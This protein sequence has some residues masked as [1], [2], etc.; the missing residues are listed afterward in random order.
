MT[1]TKPEIE[2]ARQLVETALMRLSRE[3]NA[4]DRDIQIELEQDPTIASGLLHILIESHSRKGIAKKQSARCKIIGNVMPL[5]KSAGMMDKCAHAVPHASPQL[6][7]NM[8][9]AST[10]FERAMLP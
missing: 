2:K 1:V 7:N 6:V 4:L 8:F 3:E 9:S 10:I 5:E